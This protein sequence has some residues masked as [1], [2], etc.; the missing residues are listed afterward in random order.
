[1]I[2]IAE[3][4]TIGGQ[5]LILFRLFNSQGCYVEVLNLGATLVSVVVPD[6]QGVLENV[7][8]RY[9]NMADYLTDTSH[10]GATVGRF[11]NRISQSQFTLNNTVYHLDANDGINS[12]H[13]GF[14]GF[15]KKYFRG[16]IENNALILSTESADGEG[17]FP[18]N[19]QFSVRYS[20]DEQ[21]TLQ[22][23]YSAVSDQDTVFN[24]TN[25]AYFD[26]S[27]GKG[28]P[29]EQELKAE[30]D[31][32]LEMNDSF[33]P[34]GKILNMEA[35]AFDFRTY[36]PFSQLM[37]LK[38][39]RLKGY[40]TYFI[41]LPGEKRASLR[42][43]VSGRQLDVY[44]NMPGVQCYTGDYLSGQHQPFSGV[45]LEA[46]GYP[47]APNHP[48]FPS[49][50]IKANREVKNYIRYHFLLASLGR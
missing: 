13:G 12:N 5:E 41:G 10:L 6:Q 29:L 11:A 42:D 23:E 19:M 2:Q 32:F 15:N 48:H 34:T 18:G 17:G 30:A 47:D 44:S 21:N 1:M 45:C 37:P 22:I 50:A 38:K 14:K 16:S 20:F 46:Q 33:L 8:L 26:L 35:T 39:E 24:P 49:C 31:T 28:K 36:T 4:Q 9:N 25:H 3:Q 40:N 43:K 7:I 27:A